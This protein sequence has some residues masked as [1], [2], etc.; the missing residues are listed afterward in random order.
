MQSQRFPQKLTKIWYIKQR[1]Q[2]LR[3]I[4][5]I[6]GS[7]AMQSEETERLR[8]MFTGVQGAGHL[9]GVAE[10]ATLHSLKKIVYF[11]S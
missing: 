3:K 4:F 8:E 9:T 5:N 10:G 1:I 7:T 6:G 11:A 2:Q